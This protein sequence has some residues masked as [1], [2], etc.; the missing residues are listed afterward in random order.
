MFFAKDEL[1][2]TTQLSRHLPEVVKRM[3]AGSGRAFVLKNNEIDC[4]LLSLNEYE[5]LMEAK[6]LLKSIYKGKTS[7]D[8]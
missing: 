1:V 2:T 5:K 6:E 7:G 3:K 4:V 8:S